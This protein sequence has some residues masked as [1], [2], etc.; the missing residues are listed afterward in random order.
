MCHIFSIL[1]DISRH[2]LLMHLSISLA[3]M[4]L[5]YSFFGNLCTIYIIL[6]VM[7]LSPW[8][9]YT[10]ACRNVIPA[11]RLCGMMSSGK[12]SC[13]Y[14]FI[15]TVLTPV[16]QRLYTVDIFI[17]TGTVLSRQSIVL[18]RL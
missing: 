4:N 18:K 14:G 1:L 7:Q 11:E 6:E 13:G 2:S 15:L 3:E 17:K 8:A 12:L 9:L 10:M 16:L 5:N